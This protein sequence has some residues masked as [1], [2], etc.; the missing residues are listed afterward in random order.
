[1]TLLWHPHQKLWNRALTDKL[2][3]LPGG[4][5][6][7]QQVQRLDSLLLLSRVIGRRCRRLGPLSLVRP[8]KLPHRGLYVDCG[9]HREATEVLLIHEWFGDR[10][11][12]L[13]FEASAE[14]IT[15][16]RRALTAVPADLRQVALV[17][18]A[19]TA[20]V[21]KLYKGGWEG[22]GDSLFAERGSEYEEVPT[23]RLSEMLR[24]FYSEHGEVP[25][26]IRMNI[27]GAEAQVL[28]DL[29]DA[30]LLSKV[31]G[32]YGMWDDLSKIDAG[33]DR[34]FRRFLN[35]RG[36]HPVTFNDRDLRIR[37]RARA[38]KYDVATSLAA[39]LRFTGPA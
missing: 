18:P 14:H 13:A 25:T 4:R 21:V 1:M 38:I 39:A 3:R 16:A 6:L 23:G 35:E 28:E 26:V 8:P 12:V 15:Y 10:L 24:E 33:R 37:L 2:G 30:G 7:A 31:S 32:F 29:A 36:I 22:R 11:S 17:G 5:R 19:E 27:E 9:T 34:D 20:S